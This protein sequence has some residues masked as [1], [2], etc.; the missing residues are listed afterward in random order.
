[1]WFPQKIGPDFDWVQFEKFKEAFNFQI[2]IRYCKL[3]FFLFSNSIEKQ[4]QL[5]TGISENDVSNN[6]IKLHI[7]IDTSYN[8]YKSY[9]IGININSNSNSNST[10]TS[11]I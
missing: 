7:N 8:S 2:N 9:N 5:K 11:R 10:I 1:M 6:N 3:F 4:L